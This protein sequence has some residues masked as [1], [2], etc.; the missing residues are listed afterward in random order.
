MP[1]ISTEIYPLFSNSIYLKIS[2]GL[3]DLYAR[4]ENKDKFLGRLGTPSYEL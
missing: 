4:F 1:R 2:G 3:Q